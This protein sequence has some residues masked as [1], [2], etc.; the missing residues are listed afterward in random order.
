MSIDVDSL[1]LKQELGQVLTDWESAPEWYKDVPFESS[2]RV[3]DQNPEVYRRESR[4]GRIAREAA[5]RES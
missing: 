3:V 2:D 1:G 4:L 5:E